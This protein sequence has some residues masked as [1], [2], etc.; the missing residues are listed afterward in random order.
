MSTGADDSSR[1]AVP[2][3]QNPQPGPSSAGHSEAEMQQP[4]PKRPKLQQ[5][6]R[7]VLLA[8]RMI[9]SVRLAQQRA[10][11][12]VHVNTAPPPQDTA[13]QATTIF[14]QHDTDGN[15]VLDQEE[16]RALLQSIGRECNRLHPRYVAHFLRVAEREFDE[17]VSLPD[18]V[19]MHRQLLVFDRLLLH[20]PRRQVAAPGAAPASTSQLKQQSS[21]VCPPVATVSLP[22]SEP[23][24]GD[25][26]GEEDVDEDGDDEDDNESDSQ[27][28]EPA[29][30]V[31]DHFEELSKLGQ[32]GYGLICSAIDRRS[33]TRV[34]IKRVRPTGD[35]LQLRCC[36]RELAILQHFGAHK[37]PNVLGLSEVLRPPGP[38]H[39]S[40]WRDLY[41]VTELLERDLQ[42]VLR[43]DQT[44]SESHLRLFTWQLLRGVHA[45]HCA[46]VIHRDIK[47]SNLLINSNGELKIADFG[48]SRGADPSFGPAISAGKATTPTLH[49]ND[50]AVL[51]LLCST[52]H[53]VTLWYRPPELLCGNLTYGSEI[54]M[55]S[56][57]V[58]IAEMLGRSPPF[59]GDNHMKMLRQIIGQIGS[60][61]DSDKRAIEDPRAVAF[62]NKIGDAEPQPWSEMYPD[63]PDG[64]LEM[65]GELL[66]FDPSKRPHAAAALRH[67][68]L[69]DLH[70]ESD[71]EGHVP[72]CAFPC[73]A[74]AELNLDHFLLAGLDAV[75]TAYPE[76]PV[77]V[78]ELHRF[79]IMHGRSV[80][81]I[82][83]DEGKDLERV[84]T[85]D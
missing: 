24:R 34:A 81:S 41:M 7:R 67:P 65:I 27:P 33:G 32:G 29:F 53:V 5:A 42:H 56:C 50:G 21:L 75:C 26:E 63:A 11:L 22:A 12:V 71:L 68:W 47:P 20:A 36:L 77:R 2:P 25:N 59:A 1:A 45:L 31:D 23:G 83:A 76:Y 16:F 74:C 6:I 40:E 73:D 60:P 55:W 39:L 51:P 3:P 54:D 64:A 61:S 58:T 66:H 18:F 43:S 62:L 14:Q 19:K 15:G 57:G 79:G 84:L 70:V 10:G 17:K 37:H 46:G 49:A 44:L 9:S 82:A 52:P 13:A 69:K 78:T 8:Q 80:G 28:A 38:G 30:C 4:P 48:I 85:W 72:Q 35:Q